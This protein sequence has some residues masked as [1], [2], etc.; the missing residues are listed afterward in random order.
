ME[1]DSF[2]PHS[3]MLQD[4]KRAEELMETGGIAESLRPAVR[5]GIQAVRAGTREAAVLNGGREHALLL[6]F[7]EQQLPGMVVAE[8][9]FVRL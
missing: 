7:L 6:Y 2:L 1:Y 3:Q 4:L 5:A 8:E 9:S